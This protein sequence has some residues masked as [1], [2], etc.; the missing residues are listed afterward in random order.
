MPKTNDAD[1]LS[2]DSFDLCI[3]VE[4]IFAGFFLQ[5]LDSSHWF[6]Y[7]L[8]HGSRLCGCH[9]PTQKGDREGFKKERGVGS[10]SPRPSCPQPGPVLLDAPPPQQRHLKLLQCPFAVWSGGPRRLTALYHSRFSVPFSTHDEPLSE[11][12]THFG[13]NTCVRKKVS[14][15][16]EE[17]SRAIYV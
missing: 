12:M 3:Y 11:H 8:C 2:L 15:H 5:V 10:R 9:E 1:T 14:I 7:F 13:S 6:I 4:E 16:F 17:I